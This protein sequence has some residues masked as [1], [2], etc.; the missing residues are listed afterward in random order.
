MQLYENCWKEEPNQRPDICKVHGVLNHLKS[1]FNNNGQIEIITKNF[2]NQNN[3][4][5]TKNCSDSNLKNLYLSSSLTVLK[6]SNISE[7][8]KQFENNDQIKV[9]AVQNCRDLNINN[10]NSETFNSNRNV[11]NIAIMTKEMVIVM[12]M[13]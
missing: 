13:V 6:G 7:K 11:S 2:N 3:S 10:L 1:Q 5:S 4:N 12:K 9:K 8:V